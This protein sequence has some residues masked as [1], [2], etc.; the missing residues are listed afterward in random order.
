MTEKFVMGLF[1]FMG[2]INLILWYYQSLPEL[3]RKM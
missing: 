3:T 1:Y 2:N